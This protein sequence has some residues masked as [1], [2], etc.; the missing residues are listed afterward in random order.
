MKKRPEVICLQRC[1]LL[2][3]WAACS[4][5]YLDLMKRNLERYSLTKLMRRKTD[6]DFKIKSEVHVIS[7]LVYQ[8]AVV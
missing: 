3:L 5:E 2:V 8:Y 1:L 6:Y 4:D 7:V